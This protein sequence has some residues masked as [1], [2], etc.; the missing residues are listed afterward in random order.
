[1]QDQPTSTVDPDDDFPRREEVE[2]LLE[3]GVVVPFVTA[4][5]PAHATCD[6]CPE[7]RRADPASVPVADSQIRGSD[8]WGYLCMDHY[9]EHGVAPG[10]GAAQVL[11]TIADA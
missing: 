4:T 2:Q 8:R 5:L 9:L 7:D 3:W 6:L 1:M 10:L 11:V